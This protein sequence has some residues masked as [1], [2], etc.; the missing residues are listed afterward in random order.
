MQARG[1][2]LFNV[3]K[4][5][6]NSSK[7]QN[8]HDRASFEATGIKNTDERAIFFD[9]LTWFMVSHMKIACSLLKFIYCMVT[10]TIHYL[11]NILMDG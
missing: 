9:Y 7:L 4:A 6:S 11:N 5:F 10:I 8:A 1:D 3:L 2:N